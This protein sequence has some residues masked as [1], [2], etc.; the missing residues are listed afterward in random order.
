MSLIGNGNVGIGTASPM[1]ALDVSMPLNSYAYIHGNANSSYPSQSFTQGFALGWNRTGGGAEANL[2]FAGSGLEIGY[3]NGPSYIFTSCVTVLNSG[4]VGIGTASPGYKLDVA[5][6]CNISGTYRVNGTPLATGGGNVNVYM[7]NG[8]VGTAPGINIYAMTG[9]VCTAGVVNSSYATVQVGTPSDVRLKRNIER[10]T[11]GL[12]LITQLCPVRAEWN[13]LAYTREGERVVSIL[14]HELREVIPDAVAP[15]RT[16][17]RAEDSEETELLG[18]DAMAITAHLI[19]AVQQL[20]QR[21]I[22][23]EERTN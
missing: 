20:H 15:F 1:G 10:L 5:G 16:K 6:D 9:I 23:L 12:P 4:K 14:A 22:V 17:L 2:I 7:N 21:L 18:Y 11:G 19:L 13:G 3:W 8:L